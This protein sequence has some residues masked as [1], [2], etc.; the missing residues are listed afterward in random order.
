MLTRRQ[1]DAVARALH[2]ARLVSLKLACEVAEHPVVQLK[3][4]QLQPQ[5]R[6]TVLATTK[7]QRLRHRHVGR[8]AE[9][10]L[11]ESLSALGNSQ[12]ELL[13][14]QRSTNSISA[15]CRGD[16]CSGRGADGSAD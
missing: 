11:L 8:G 3:S 5:A 2:T 1:I 13:Q 12:T 7:Q 4:L 14:V 10:L 9:R 6:R 16:E 15:A